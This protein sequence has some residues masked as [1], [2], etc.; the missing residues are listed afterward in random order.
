MLRAHRAGIRRRDRVRNTL[1][2]LRDMLSSSRFPALVHL[3]QLHPIK[4]MAIREAFAIM[5][6]RAEI[7]SEHA[8]P[9]QRLHDPR[10]LAASG[11]NERPHL[12]FEF[13]MLAG[14]LLQLMAHRHDLTH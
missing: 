5:P 8:P 4:T 13:G 14:K 6:S 2:T 7:A 9:R 1:R 11:I 12:F 3:F 10:T